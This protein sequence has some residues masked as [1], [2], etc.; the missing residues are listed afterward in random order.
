M[1]PDAAKLHPALPHPL[2]GRFQATLSYLRF[3]NEDSPWDRNFVVQ[4]PRAV[5]TR[6]ICCTTID[7]VQQ[8]SMPARHEQRQPPT[9]DGPSPRPV[10]SRADRHAA[11]AD[12]LGLVSSHGGT[13]AS[14]RRAA[15]HR[16][17]SSSANRSRGCVGKRCSTS[18]KYTHGLIRKRR[19]VCV[20]LNN[21][22]A[23]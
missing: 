20:K 17:G 22:S 7:L 8:L 19:H 5:M 23:V 9:Q 14:A 3:H 21:T 2:P 15:A 10:T 13:P 11:F 6:L 12:S 4:I 18:R 1:R 16:S